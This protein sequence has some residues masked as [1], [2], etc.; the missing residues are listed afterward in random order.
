VDLD[1]GKVV[2]RVKDVGNNSHGL[3]AWR[4]RFVMLS[5]KETALVTVDPQTERVTHIWQV[6][7]HYHRLM[8]LLVTACT[9]RGAK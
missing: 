8:L 6:H 1:S 7:L 3:V 4:G 5:S 2:R 9:C